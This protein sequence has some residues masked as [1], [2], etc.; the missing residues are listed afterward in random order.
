MLGPLPPTALKVNY[1]VLATTLTQNAM[2][3]VPLAAVNGSLAW[4]AVD[5]A[6]NATACPADAT[7]FVCAFTAQFG[8]WPKR[9]GQGRAAL[10]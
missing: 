6:A 9:N 5:N 8:L 2:L 7:A 10:T 4:N 1:V 3:R